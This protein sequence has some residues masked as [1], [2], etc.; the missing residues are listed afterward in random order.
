MAVDTPASIAIIGAGP[1]GLET[2]LYARF[3]GY[4]VTLFEQREIC[5]GVRSWGHVKMFT[6]LGMNSSPLGLAAIEAHDENIVFPA[7]DAILTGQEWYEKYLL[8]LSQ[9]DLLVDNIR[10]G[11][12]VVAITKENL[13]KGDLVG[14]EERGDWSFEV[15][16]LDPQNELRLRTE[17]F[18]VVIDCSGV[19]AQPRECGLGGGRPPLPLAEEKFLRTEIPV[20]SDNHISGERAS[21]LEFYGGKTTLLVGGGYSAATAAVMWKELADQFPGTKLIWSTRRARQTSAD[22]ISGPIKRIENDALPTRDALAREANSLTMPGN[23]F[24]IEH[25]SETMV[26][27]IESTADGRLEVTLRG[28]KPSKITVDRILSLCGY[29]PDLDL[30]RELQVHL[31]YATEGPMRLAASLMKSDKSQG[32]SADCLKTS[33]GGPEDL[34]T[35]EPNFYILGAKSYG[36]RSDFLFQSGLMQIRDL[37]RII[38][39]RDSLDL[40]QSARPLPK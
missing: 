21:S 39:D 34:L 22:G 6:P 2:A 28:E 37:F 35:T 29:R 25:L 12:K 13:L 27:R 33:S 14:D 7:A 17:Q 9:T 38:G 32:S 31:C 24:R 30:F 16:Y 36:R 19:L 1:I 5:S 20:F 8:P 15:T 18:D 11:T 40:Y 4:D 3:L 10:I 23:G 26:E